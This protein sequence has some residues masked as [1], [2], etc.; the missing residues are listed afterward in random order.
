MDRARKHYSRIISLSCRSDSI[1]ITFNNSCDPTVRNDPATFESQL[2][3]SFRVTSFPPP[4][5]V[6]SSTSCRSCVP[7]EPV[8]VDCARFEEND[9]WSVRERCVTRVQLAESLA[10]EHA[11]VGREA[12]RVVR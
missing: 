1:G 6:S 12:I 11:E 9:G 3:G 8:P 4:F 5:S 2:R 7:V 10:Y